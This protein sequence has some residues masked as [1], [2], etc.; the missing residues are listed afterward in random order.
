MQ[1]NATQ[2]GNVAYLRIITYYSSNILPPKRYG[3]PEAG[4]DSYETA[5]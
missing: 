2:T 5:K 3:R 1:Q 4:Y